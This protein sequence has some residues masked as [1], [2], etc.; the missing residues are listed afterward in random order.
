ML[1]RGTTLGAAWA[2]AGAQCRSGLER[3]W[4]WRWDLGE[5]AKLG[6]AGER[7]HLVGLQHYPT[8]FKDF[9]VIELENREVAKFWSESQRGFKRT[10]LGRVT[11]AQASL[12]A[13]I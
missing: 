6:G 13:C 10:G 8:T 4:S 2:G 5:P 9:S 3:A 12:P 11:V 7:Q 1:W